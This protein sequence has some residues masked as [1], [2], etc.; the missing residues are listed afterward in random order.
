MGVQALG[1]KDDDAVA[2]A[3]SF[4]KG[5]VDITIR[6]VEGKAV[7]VKSSLIAAGHRALKGN[8]AISRGEVAAM[9]ITTK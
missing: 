4:K 1:I 6:L 5:P 3:L 9:E 8:K 7:E 2:A